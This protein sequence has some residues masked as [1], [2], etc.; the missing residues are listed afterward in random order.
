MYNTY[1]FVAKLWQPGS[2]E[3]GKKLKNRHC[4][5]KAVR[6]NQ[7]VPQFFFQSS[8]YSDSL[9]PI[10]VVRS[11]QNLEMIEKKLEALF[12]SVAVKTLILVVYELL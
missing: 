8:P 6:Q 10:W 11:Y 2:G 3:A 1:R 12:D 4:Q 5:Q 7:K 9:W